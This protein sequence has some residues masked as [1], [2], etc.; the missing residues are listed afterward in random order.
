VSATQIRQNLTATTML[1]PDEVA[2][3]LDQLFDPGAAIG[4]SFID[5]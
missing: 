5:S 1:I 3:V 2:A 4:K